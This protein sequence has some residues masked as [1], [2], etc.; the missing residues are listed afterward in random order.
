[1]EGE[2]LDAHPR[3]ARCE[4]CGS[5]SRNVEGIDDQIERAVLSHS[6]PLAAGQ[7]LHLLPVCVAAWRVGVCC[8]GMSAATRHSSIHDCTTLVCNS[9]AFQPIHQSASNA[10]CPSTGMCSPLPPPCGSLSQ[11]W[12]TYQTGVRG[13]TRAVATSFP[14]P[15]QWVEKT[16][17]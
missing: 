16:E 5:A 3:T 8:E 1:M 10:T 9:P 6:F 12:V 11:S 7:T 2:R 14:P 17:A 13:D 4:W 15:L